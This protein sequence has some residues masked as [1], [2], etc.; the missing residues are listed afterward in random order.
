MPQQVTLHLNQLRCIVESDAQGGSE[1][2]LWVTYF[3]VDGRNITQPEPVF[4]NTPV[5]NDFRREV[6]DNVRDG[7]VVNVPPF[8][9]NFSAEVDPGPLNFMMVGCLVVLL[10]EDETPDGAIFAGRNAFATGIHQELNKLIKERIRTLER[11]PVTDEEVKAIRDAIEPKVESAIRSRLSLRQKL[12]G[13]QDDVLGFAHVTFIGDE[14]QSKDF[15]F[16]ELAERGGGNRF[17]LSGRLGVAPVGPPPFD[18]CAD[19]RAGVQD[20]RD[21][22]NGL[23]IRLRSLQQELQTAPPQAKPAIV[24]QITALG[25]EIT[26]AQEELERAE[27]SLRKCEAGITGQGQVSSGGILLD[28]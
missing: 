25:P 22:L 16:P 10:E 4:T 18:P 8:L 11:G 5:F 13:N 7:Q 17:V 21:Q 2:Y 28:V 15:E 14:I 20:K 24:K 6:P 23:N 27:R 1:P 9:A 26:R 3:V 19:R 12:F